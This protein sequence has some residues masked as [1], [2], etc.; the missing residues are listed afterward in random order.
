MAGADI[1]AHIEEIYAAYARGE[2]ARFAAA[3]HDDV[4]W[5]IYGPVEVFPFMGPRRGKQAVIVTLGEI[6][7]A[8]EVQ[9]YRPEVIIVEGNRAAVMS[10]TSFRQRETNRVLRFRT[11]DFL[12]VENNLITEFREF[13]NTFDVAEQ[14]LGRW[15]QI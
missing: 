1:R 4:D 14:A 11:A 3:L 12:L 7:A 13:A 5:V 15:L 10:D 6:A 2:S 9:S 8:Y